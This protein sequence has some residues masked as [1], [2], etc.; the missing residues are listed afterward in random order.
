MLSPL[1]FYNL[2]MGII[3]SFQV[4]GAAFVIGG[5]TG[6]PQES[7]LMYMVHLYRTAFRYFNMGYASAIAYALVSLTLVLSWARAR[8]RRAAKEAMG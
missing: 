8:L 1:I 4:L 2:V 5:T 7:L 3:G 6:K